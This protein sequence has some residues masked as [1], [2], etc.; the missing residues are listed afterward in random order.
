MTY[1]LS[2]TVCATGRSLF[3]FVCVCVC[4]YDVCVCLSVSIVFC[5]FDAL[6]AIPLSEIPLKN[7]CY[8]L[9]SDMGA[10]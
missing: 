9:K 1:V 5:I 2:Y 4:A 10:F 6:Q 7:I 8:K 3:G